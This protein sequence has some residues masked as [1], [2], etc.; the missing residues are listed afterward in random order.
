M[1]GYATEET[2]FKTVFLEN[3]DCYAGDLQ[4]VVDGGGHFQALDEKGKE[5]SLQERG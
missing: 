5:R 1:A 2:T 4:G 3:V